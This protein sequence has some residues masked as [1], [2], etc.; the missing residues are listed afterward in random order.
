MALELFHAEVE[1]LRFEVEFFDL[2][3]SRLV[4]DETEGSAPRPE[5][6]VI[7][8]GDDEPGRREHFS[9]FSGNHE[10]HTHPCMRHQPT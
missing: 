3:D 8:A 1:R 7:L 2:V 9:F 10:K 6:G 4:R 5:A